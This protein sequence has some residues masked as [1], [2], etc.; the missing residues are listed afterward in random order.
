MKRTYHHWED[1]EC[2]KA[3]FYETSPPAGTTSGVAIAMYAEFLLDIPRFAAAMDRVVDEW[4]NSCEHFLSN[5]NINR[6]AWLG[7][8]SMCIDTRVPAIYR[9]GFS[10][11]S[12]AAQGRANS[13][14]AG[15]LHK[16]MRGAEEHGFTLMPE[17]AQS[18]GLENIPHARG[19]RARIAVYVDY[20]MRRGYPLGIPDEVPHRL[21]KLA[22]A[23]SYKAIGLA[24]LRNDLYLTAL[25]FAAPQ[26]SWYGALKRIEIEARRGEP[27]PQLGWEF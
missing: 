8:A 13:A 25:G 6:L 26:S 19:V 15:R 14:A 20:W 7:Q 16:W 23:P 12:R 3:G 17:S 5:R 27:R 21:M 10:R 24:I 22:I 4:P 18:P 11:L 9:G 1:W 2:C